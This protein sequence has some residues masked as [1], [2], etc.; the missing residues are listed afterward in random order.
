MDQIGVALV[1]FGLAG[2]VFH[3]PLIEQAPDLDL[4]VI[5]TGNQR[6]RRIATERYPRA[7]LC[8]T[9][10]D[11]LAEPTPVSLVVIATPNHLHL[12]QARA[13]MEHGFNVVVDKPLALNAAEAE[14]LIEVQERQRVVLSVF[15]NRRWDNDF[16]LMR[17]T[18]D[19]GALG[20]VFEFESRFERW[21]PDVQA[22]SWREQRTSADG[23]GLLLD[24]GSHLVDQALELF[25]T[26]KTVYAERQRRRPGVRA[27]DHCFLA[28]GFAGGTRAHLW[29]SAMSAVP[30][31][32]FR[33]LGDRGSLETWGLDPQEDQLKEGKG[34]ADRDYGQAG[35]G[36]WVRMVAG[37]RSAPDS[38]QLTL[39][40]GRYQEYYR[41]MVWALRHQGPVPVSPQ[42][43]LEC[44]RIIDLAR[45]LDGTKSLLDPEGAPM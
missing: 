9:M 42:S 38:G 27:E 13:A 10:D 19:G 39:P 11:F 44:L 23:G 21:R 35:E 2:A 45:T 1:G 25:G 28:L 26:P 43:A 41:G 18:L 8:S 37:D 33:V 20:T 17:R 32:R 29:M 40:A 31:P 14:R 16:L 24:L 7:R 5:V 34:P 36:Q 22:D 4:R 30:G 12:P 6:R 15:H 3:A